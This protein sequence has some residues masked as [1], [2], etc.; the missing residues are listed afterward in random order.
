VAAIGGHQVD[1]PNS[2]TSYTTVAAYPVIYPIAHRATVVL[3]V[4]LGVMVAFWFVGGMGA[5]FRLVRQTTKEAMK[6]VPSL[7]EIDQQLRAEG[8]DPSISD[9]VA[10]HG[11]L[12]S[13]RNE[14]ALLAGALII[15]P[16]LLARQAQGKPL[17]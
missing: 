3:A 15:G 17:F 12:T 4:S 9:L 5:Y 1:G 8:H 7:A 14:A 11:Y 16:H 13:Q 6:P 2:N 10:M